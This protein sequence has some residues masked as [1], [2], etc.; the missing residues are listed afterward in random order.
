MEV[1]P[2]QSHPNR[3][4]I[5]EQLIA[6]GRIF[7]SLRGSNL[8]SYSGRAAQMV[9]ESGGIFGGSREVEKTLPMT[10]QRVI[11]DAEAFYQLQ[12]D[13]SLKLISLSSLD[14]YRVSNINDLVMTNFTH[15][16]PAQNTG[17][18]PID[19]GT[20]QVKHGEKPHSMDIADES[21]IAS[22][23]PALDDF[24]RM[25]A[26]PRVKGFALKTKQWCQFYISNISDITWSSNIVE[27]LVL[28]EDEKNLLL[29]LLNPA[30]KSASEASVFD[31]FI[32]K[33]GKG[34]IILLSG[35]PGVGK[36]L[37]G[38]AVAE[39]LKRPLYQLG[40][41]DIG[42]S[43]D[44]VEKQLQRAFARCAHWNAILL[45][46]EADVYLEARSNNDLQR[47]E[48]VTV[49]LRLVE[50]YEG[51]MILTT[52]RIA[53][54]DTAFESRIDISLG[55]RDLDQDARAQIWRNFIDHV[56]Q[57]EKALGRDGSAISPSEVLELSRIPLNGK[58]IKS[59]VKMACILAK[60][61]DVIIIIERFGILPI[62]T[63]LADRGARSVEILDLAYSSRQGLFSHFAVRTGAGVS[64]AVTS[65]GSSSVSL[66]AAYSSNRALA[67]LVSLMGVPADYVC[68]SRRWG[69]SKFLT[70]TTL[71][72]DAH[73]TSIKTS[74]MPKTFQDAI[75]FTRSL[76]LRYL[77]IDS[78]CIIQDDLDDWKAEAEAMARVY[79]NSYLTLMAVDAS[80]AESGLF[81]PVKGRLKRPCF[82]GTTR[83][84]DHT[85][86]Q[87]ESPDTLCFIQ[88]K[89]AH[90][91]KRLDAM[92]SVTSALQGIYWE[93]LE[94]SA[95]ETV[96]GDANITPE[97]DTPNDLVRGLTIIDP[98]ERE[99]DESVGTRANNT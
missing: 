41:G 53:S 25:L 81:R 31:D 90:C 92:N 2:L 73:K 58:Q 33:K 61:E 26:V 49:F 62:Y 71:N 45:I 24:E 96:P 78:L 11:I 75:S 13:K 77:W 64:A 39:H 87:G 59:A 99:D 19:I 40:A 66:R 74:D 16:R 3:Q 30:S 54:I 85:L 18:T 6:R 95:S 97:K 1:F 84:T 51:I 46:D 57:L 5:L 55:F 34:T 4:T 89:D 65:P 21:K 42:T 38:E 98:F 76:G 8:R 79:M 86:L 36:T 15:S 20:E 27:K 23:S 80:S 7:E 70:T 43:V 94:T 63:A 17:E 22:V 29:A 56:G 37:T 9:K 88:M 47:N 69:D 32:S 48:L 10:N 35:A 72:I 28:G 52:N 12:D 67:A 91:K 83:V 50:Y 82:I 93:C 60:N 44:K 14:E 68:L